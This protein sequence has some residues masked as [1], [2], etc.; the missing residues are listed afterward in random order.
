MAKSERKTYFE[1]AAQQGQTA[2]VRYLLDRGLTPS[3]RIADAMGMA[4]IQQ[5]NQE[6]T[7]ILLERKLLCRDTALHVSVFHNRLHTI[8]EFDLASD[9]DEPGRCAEKAGYHG[10]LD[11]LEYLMKHLPVSEHE[12]VLKEVYR[13]AGSVAVV[14]YCL[15][16]LGPDLAHPIRPEALDQAMKESH[17]E[18]VKYFIAQGVEVDE[19]EVHDTLSHRLQVGSYMMQMLPAGWSYDDYPCNED[20]ML[21][22]FTLLDP[23]REVEPNFAATAIERRFWRLAELFLARPEFNVD[24][25]DSYYAESIVPILRKDG[26]EDIIRR[27]IDLDTCES[28]SMNNDGKIPSCNG[29]TV[30]GVLNQ[31]RYDEYGP[32]SSD[33]ARI[34]E[35]IAQDKALAKNELDSWNFSGVAGYLVDLLLDHTMHQPLENFI[36]PMNLEPDVAVQ[37]CSSLRRICA[38]VAQMLQSRRKPDTLMP[39]LKTALKSLSQTSKCE[40]ISTFFMEGVCPLA[41]ERGD[42]LMF[43]MFVEAT[44]LFDFESGERNILAAIHGGVLET[45]QQYI[46]R[47]VYEDDNDWVDHYHCDLEPGEDPIAGRARL[48]ANAAFDFNEPHWLPAANRVIHHSDPSILH[49]LWPTMW[50][51]TDSIELYVALPLLNIAFVQHCPKLISTLTCLGA[52]YSDFWVSKMFEIALWDTGKVRLQDIDVFLKGAEKY[53]TRVPVLKPALLPTF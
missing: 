21:Y 9:E 8:K 14:E 39:V 48:I 33:A 11:M 26:R 34:T 24:E 49:H 15:G 31:D 27:L 25:L 17:M 23:D 46:Y 7:R 16:L 52:N 40:K 38:I 32:L 28:H 41:L 43:A 42:E 1:I 35:R 45:V 3:E 19:E 30:A 12:R 37:V 5:D 50:N 36:R 13:D 20:D 53:Q 18:V 29:C 22:L 4:A 44:G 10:H 47:P 6:L 2:M 51:P